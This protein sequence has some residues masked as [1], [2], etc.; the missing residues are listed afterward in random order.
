MNMGKKYKFTKE[1]DLCDAFLSC[2]PVD[3]TPYNETGGYDIVLVHDTGVQIGIEAKLTLNAKV[4][5]QVIPRRSMRQGGAFP[6]FLAVLVGSYSADMKALSDALQITV[7]TVIPKWEYPKHYPL[8]QGPP[9]KRF[10]LDW[11]RGLPEFR[12]NG[13]QPE[14]YHN[15]WFDSENWY[16]QAPVRRIELPEYVPNVQAGC[17]SPQ[18]LSTWKIKAMKVCIWVERNK[19]ITRQHF[20][21]L[22]ID[23]NRWMNGYWLKKTETRGVWEA[24]EHMPTET[25]RAQH[26]ET[27]SE[28]EADYA[29]WSKL[30][31]K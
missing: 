30:V 19:T 26:P 3:W 2:V 14:Q 24:G 18:V 27:F 11:N 16:D 17:P 31:P 6:D 1:A 13:Y 7:L 10:E 28:I 8:W 23:P 20:K 22:M 29:E 4:L 25:Y 12:A 5:N 15:R 9:Q 21:A